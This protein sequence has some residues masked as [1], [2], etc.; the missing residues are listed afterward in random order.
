MFLS[1]ISPTT[2][3]CLVLT[4]YLVVHVSSSMILRGVASSQI[5]SKP[6]STTIQN[7][8]GYCCLPS[9]GSFSSIRVASYNQKPFSVSKEIQYFEFSTRSQ[10]R[11]RKDVYVNDGMTLD[12]STIEFIDQN[13]LYSYYWKANRTDC[14]CRSLYNGGLEQ[15]FGGNNNDWNVQLLNVFG[16]NVTRLYLT[17]PNTGENHD[18]WFISNSEKM[19]KNEC[20]PFR[21]LIFAD[22]PI[23]AGG[24]YVD[25][26]NFYNFETSKVDPSLFDL[27]NKCIHVNCKPF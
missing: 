8:N 12:S 4:S 10:P 23:S 16:M 18:N 15:C 11:L 19:G 21:S 1:M 13:V 9:H 22:G 20:F 27:P 26:S 5:V 24:Y 2:L 14:M 6:M 7:N 25:E 17:N 3:L